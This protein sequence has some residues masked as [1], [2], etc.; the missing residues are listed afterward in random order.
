MSR[1]TELMA[2]PGVVAAGM[3]SRKGL[4]E[5]FEGGLP[6]SEAVGLVNLCSAVTLIMEMQGRLLGRIAGQTG[7]NGHCAWMMWG[8]EKA[9]VTVSDTVCVAQ[10]G[11]TS[12]NQLIQ[13]MQT[14]AEVELFKPAEEGES[15]GSTE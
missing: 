11:A 5:Q 3:Y 9:I 14:S 7:W 12:F 2:V 8:P 4:M 6:E 15:H 13:A 10:A 1:T